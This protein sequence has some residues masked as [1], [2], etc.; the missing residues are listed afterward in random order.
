MQCVQ[1]VINDACS[2]LWWN[3]GSQNCSYPSFIQ[4]WRVCYFNPSDKWDFFFFLNS[5]NCID[6]GMCEHYNCPEFCF[7]FCVCFR[8]KGD[9][10]RLGHGTDVHV[11][12][13]QVVEGL[14]GKKIVHVAV[15]ALHCLAVTDT[16]QVCYLSPSFPLFSPSIKKQTMEEDCN[17]ISVD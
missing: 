7:Y 12:K 3:V 8:G 16:G 14:R 6:E 10:F 5:G 17:S 9:Y 2:R 15:G 4:F 13:P 11:R 1:K